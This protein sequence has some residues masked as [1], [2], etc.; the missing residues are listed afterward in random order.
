MEDFHRCSKGIWKGYKRLPQGM[1]VINFENE[2]IHFSIWM[3]T[4][5]NLIAYKI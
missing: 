3:H 2:C 5:L 1:Y 4:K